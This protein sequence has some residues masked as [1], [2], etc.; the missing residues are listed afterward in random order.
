M[1][2]LPSLPDHNPPKLKYSLKMWLKSRNV[3]QVML[4]GGHEWDGEGK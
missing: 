1:Y 2:I 3:K 4:R